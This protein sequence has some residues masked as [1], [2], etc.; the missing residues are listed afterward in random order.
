MADLAVVPKRSQLNF[1]PERQR[2]FGLKVLNVTQRVAVNGAA[3]FTAHLE[4]GWGMYFNGRVFGCVGSE[5]DVL[6]YLTLFAPRSF[7]VR[8]PIEMHSILVNV[9]F[10][11]RS[12]SLNRLDAEQHTFSPVRRK[13]DRKSTRLN[14]SHLGISYAVFC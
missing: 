12:C 1:E 9:R 11:R 2:F 6:K 3:R 13:S 8:T 10:D 5:F 14:S 7:A 4:L